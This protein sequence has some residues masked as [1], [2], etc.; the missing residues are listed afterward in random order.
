MILVILT[1][2]PTA[3]RSSQDRGQVQLQPNCDIQLHFLTVT[4]FPKN[5]FGL[6]FGFDFWL[7]S[8]RVYPHAGHPSSV[9]LLAHLLDRTC[10]DRVARAKFVSYV[11]SGR[12]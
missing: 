8:R 12:P 6:H 4:K 1:A 7:Q 10:E 3:A 2:T 11:L 5:I 9:A